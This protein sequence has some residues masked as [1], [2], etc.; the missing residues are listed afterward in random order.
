[1][2]ITYLQINGVPGRWNSWT[3]H[4]HIAAPNGTK[5]CRPREKYRLI[6][7]LFSGQLQQ[8]SLESRWLL[9]LQSED[10]R[11]TSIWEMRWQTYGH[12]A[13]G[14]GGTSTQYQ[15]TESTPD[16]G[17]KGQS[18]GRKLNW[19]WTTVKAPVYGFDPESW[20]GMNGS[21]WASEVKRQSYRKLLIILLE[22]DGAINLITADRTIFLLLFRA[23]PVSSG[24]LLKRGFCFTKLFRFDWP[25]WLACSYVPSTIF[26]TCRHNRLGPARDAVRPFLFGP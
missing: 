16:M 1:M 2:A 10:A 22:L 13:D 25:P 4:H 7:E 24:T 26:C 8:T 12:G 21:E 11:A 15:Y 9:S 18:P 3:F 5:K 20:P 23:Y 17:S 14:R 6:V 19:R